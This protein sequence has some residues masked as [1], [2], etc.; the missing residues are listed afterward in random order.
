M[1]RK[2]PSANSEL[3]EKFSYLTYPLDREFEQIA[4]EFIDTLPP[5]IY[6]ALIEEPITSPT[7]HQ[8]YVWRHS[9]ELF[10]RIKLLLASV[11]GSEKAALY[12]ELKKDEKD[13]LVIEVAL[14]LAFYAMASD[15]WSILEPAFK[16]RK[17]HPPTP[18]VRMYTEPNGSY[19]KAEVPA[20]ELED[21]GS[22]GEAALEFIR[23]RSIR[24]VAA[25]FSP[26]EVMQTVGGHR[27]RA[28][29]W[30]VVLNHKTPKSLRKQKLEHLNDTVLHMPWI[31]YPQFCDAILH[32]KLKGK[33][34]IKSLENFEKVAEADSKLQLRIARK[35]HS[36]KWTHGMMSNI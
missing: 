10:E 1:P 5:K 32:Q 29:D 21:I 3:K 14:F 20:T 6:R 12:K 13:E 30:E 22:P 7:P 33:R 27:R 8:F 24:R 26:N 11:Y 34:P 4:V 16:A 23:Y 28:K 19:L 18:W 25:A 31:T 15:C 17:I 2:I 36:F 35:S 9:T